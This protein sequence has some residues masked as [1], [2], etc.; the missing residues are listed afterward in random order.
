MLSLGMLLQVSGPQLPCLQ[1][2]YQGIAK[3][4]EIP[5][6]QGSAQAWHVTGTLRILGSHGSWVTW[7]NCPQPT[8][9]PGRG[10]SHSS[11]LQQ[12]RVVFSLVLVVKLQ[13]AAGPPARENTLQTHVAPLCSTWHEEAG[14]HHPVGNAF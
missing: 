7:Q 12:A 3:F 9:V 5:C 14:A 13:M 4:Q 2:G 8:L 6:T 11:A 1:S 10:Q